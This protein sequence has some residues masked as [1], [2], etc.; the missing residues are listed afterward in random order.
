MRSRQHNRGKSREQIE[1]GVLKRCP[2]C[3][4]TSNYVIPS[5]V[6]FLATQQAAKAEFIQGY[7]ARLAQIPCK[8]FVR[9]LDQGRSGRFLCPFGKDCVSR[10]SI[11]EVEPPG[12]PHHRGLTLCLNQSG[13]R[14][15]NSSTSTPT[16]MEHRTSSPTAWP[17]TSW[18]PDSQET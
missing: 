12:V 7:K 11:V 3:R 4:S 14:P 5:N 2:A 9:S 18:L 1:G 15:H 6:V 16:P 8:H 10:M 13:H 17:T